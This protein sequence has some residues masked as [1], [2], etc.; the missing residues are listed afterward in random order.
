M[1]NPKTPVFIV[2][3]DWADP[4]PEDICQYVVVNTTTG[5][6]IKRYLFRHAA[7]AAAAELNADLMTTD[8]IHMVLGDALLDAGF[9]SPAEGWYSDPEHTRS[10][11]LPTLTSDERRFLWAWF[12]RM[13]P[14][15]GRS[16]RHLI[17]LC[18]AHADS[19][20]F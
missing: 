13:D 12:S 20:P 10:V 16:I 5:L 3:D 8:E 18:A 2:R 14:P 17:N 9:S 7:E 19:A 6:D 15:G 1:P 4:T 11:H